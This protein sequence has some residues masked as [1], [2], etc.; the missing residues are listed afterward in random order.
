M[1]KQENQLYHLDCDVYSGI[2]CPYC[3]QPSDNIRGVE[4]CKNE[5]EEL[6]KRAFDHYK[7]RI[8]RSD[9][10]VKKAMISLI[11]EGFD[12]GSSSLDEL[13]AIDATP[14]TS[15]FPLRLELARLEY[16]REQN[17]TDKKKNN[18]LPLGP[19]SRLTIVRNH[20]LE[21]AIE[22]QLSTSRSSAR[23]HLKRKISQEDSMV[24]F[25]DSNS[26]SLSATKICEDEDDGYA[27]V[28]EET[29][30]EHKEIKSI[31]REMIDGD[32]TIESWENTTATDGEIRNAA[33]RIKVKRVR[34]PK[35]AI[36]AKVIVSSG[37]LFGTRG[38]CIG[39]TNS[40]ESVRME[41]D[42]NGKTKRTAVLRKNVSIEESP[43]EMNS[44]PS[45]ESKKPKKIFCVCG[46]PQNG[47]YVKCQSN[48]SGCNGWVHPRC[49]PDLQNLTFEELQIVDSR[50]YECIHCKTI[51]NTDDKKRV[52]MPN[53]N[54]KQGFSPVDIV[55]ENNVKGDPEKSGTVFSKSMIG[56]TVYLT[57]GAHAGCVATVVDI[58]ENGMITVAITEKRY[59]DKE[60]VPSLS[61]PYLAI[62][63]VA[64]G[65][66]S[67]D[68]NFNAPENSSSQLNLVSENVPQGSSSQK[69][70]LKSEI[71][72]SISENRQK[73]TRN[74]VVS[75]NAG[76][77]DEHSRPI[78]YTIVSAADRNALIMKWTENLA[79]HLPGL[80]GETIKR[81][82]S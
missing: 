31:E 52:E 12:F 48:I 54:L 79:F 18:S 5:E 6:I 23:E 53:L 66:S 70:K 77:S 69:P 55:T 16:A 11:A 36:G 2:S 56:K 27:E 21:R 15:S 47:V 46:Q 34:M 24:K 7:I 44:V 19:L 13:K 40:G 49:C 20:I 17:S 39:Y 80:V 59:N 38:T 9:D 32:A 22:M 14:T 73:F 67:S 75:T 76:V 82:V 62:P 33:K 29:S 65:K 81:P 78:Q 45:V 25:K 35:I 4:E 68:D 42:D 41:F 50:G 43:I 72:N 37:N 74:V 3:R 57:N 61:A 60:Q 26:H 58:L 30:N 28:M 71:D 8:S 51:S 64:T 10:G 63:L 1:L